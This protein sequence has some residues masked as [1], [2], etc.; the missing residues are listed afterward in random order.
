M[1]FSNFRSHDWLEALPLAPVK[2]FLQSPIIM[3]ASFCCLSVECLT[4]GAAARMSTD[5]PQLLHA[6]LF[7]TR[8][9]GSV[10]NISTCIFE[11]Q[12]IFGIF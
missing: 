10:K 2:C 3:V 6:F 1:S 12:E 9:Y 7:R 8:K 5:Q 11:L 4:S